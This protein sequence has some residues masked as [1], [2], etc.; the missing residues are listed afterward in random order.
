MTMNISDHKRTIRLY[1]EAA[2]VWLAS[3]KNPNVT[4]PVAARP[5]E[6]MPAPRP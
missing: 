3:A 4:S 5:A 2:S 1:S 6:R